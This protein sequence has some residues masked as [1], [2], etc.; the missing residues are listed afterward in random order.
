MGEPVISVR[1][2]VIMV[3]NAKGQ[4]PGQLFSMFG[5]MEQSTDDRGVYRIYG[6][7]PGTYIVSAGG[8]SIAQPYLFNPYDTDAPT[9]APS[10][11]RDDA[12]E[13]TVRAGEE[14]NV[15][16]RYRGEPGH[17]VSGTVR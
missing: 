12:A 16:I 15:D 13:V 6:I 14:S 3:R 17:T 11:T 4:R 7:S 1:V 10:S 8:T 2:R 9:Y 5:S